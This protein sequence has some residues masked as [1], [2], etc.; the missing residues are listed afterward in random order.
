M[1]SPSEKYRV[2]D[3]LQRNGY[4]LSSEDLRSFTLRKIIR[5]KLNPIKKIKEEKEIQ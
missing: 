1:S 4:T 2:I 5:K 3:F